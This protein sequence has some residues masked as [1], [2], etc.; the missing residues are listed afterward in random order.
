MRFAMAYRMHTSMSKKVQL[1]T[2]AYIAA[3]LL[4]AWLLRPSPQDVAHRIFGQNMVPSTKKGVEALNLS[5]ILM[6]RSEA[7]VVLKYLR[8]D[9]HTYLEWGS[10]GSTVNFPQYASTRAVSIEH[11]KSWC[12]KMRESVKEQ[13]GVKVEMRCVPVKRGTKGWGLRSP[14]EEGNYLVFRSYIDEIDRLQQQSWDFVLIDGRARVDAAIKAL[15][16]LRND[17]IVVLHDSWRMRWKYGEVYDYYD[18][19]E[20]TLLMWN[21]GVAI[22]KRKPAF[23]YVEEKPEL[24]QGILNRKYHLT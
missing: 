13:R 1:R 21:Q 23:A 3:F 5:N 6:T 18:V 4:L 11:D 12:D 14:F 17:S 19:V 8:R 20:E 24:V 9:V 16:Y 15:S 2:G 10:G 22:L 7:N